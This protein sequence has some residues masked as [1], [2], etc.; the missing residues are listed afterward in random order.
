MSARQAELLLPRLVDHWLEECPAAR[1]LM[2]D[3][4]AESEMGRECL[5]ADGRHAAREA[6]LALHH[7]DLL[8]ITVVDRPGG[9]SARIAA[10]RRR[11]RA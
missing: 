2:E 1:T 5:R 6:L 9:L 4:L 8:Q 3:W 10:A 11:A 7:F